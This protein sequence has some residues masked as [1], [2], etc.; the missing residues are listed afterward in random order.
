MS[1]RSFFAFAT[2]AFFSAIAIGLPAAAAETKRDIQTIKDADFFGFD[3]RTEQNVSLD[4]CK[5]SCIGDKSCKAFTYNPKVKWCFLKSDF[6]TMNAFP[7][8]VAGKIVETAAQKEPDIGAAPR[9]TFLSND[10]IQ[11]AHDY[12]DNLA[13]ADG[14]QG[15]G[16][17][18]LTANARLDMTENNLTDALIAFHGALSI[19]PDDA[20]LWLETARAAIS[21]GSTESSVTGQAVVDALNGYELTRTKA[22]RAEALAVLA[23]ALERNANYRPALGAYK[24][25]LALIASDEVQTAYLQ[26]KS[27]QGFR[28]TEHT[29]DADSV[30]PRACA[31]FSEALVKTTDYTPFVT[32]NGAA[33]KAVETKDKQICVEGLTHGETYKITFRPGLPSSVDESLDAPVSIDVYIKD[34]SQIVRFTG[35]SFVL[36]STA[37]RGIPIVSVNLAS[38]NLKLYRIG[39]R[40]IAPLLTNSQFLSQL[41]GYSAQNI[42][43][44]SGE[45]VW[46]GSID[47]ANE[48]NKDIVTSFPVDE[49]LPERKPGIYVL[50]A[51]APNAPAQEWDSQATQWFLVSDIGIT[52]YAGT[53]GLNVFARSLASAKPIAGVEL[54]LLAKNNEVLGTATTDE[55]GRATFTAGL[56]RGTAALTPAVIAA[57]NGTSDYVFLDMTRAG[58]D[59]SDRGV[60]GRVAPGA[61]DVLTFTERGIYR[62][63]ET[64]HTQALARDTDGNAIENLPLTF[65]FSRPDGVEDRRIVSQ[66]SNLGGYSVDFATQANAM[67]GTWTMNIYTDP[68]GSAI[69]SKS[70]LIDDFVPDR[71]DME[72]KTE[73]K[74]IGPD[75]P[76]NIT[77]SGKYLYGAPAAGLTLEGDVVVKPTRENEAY[78]GFLFGLA[79]EEASED[80]R[81][82]I[83]DLPELDENGE[84]STDLTVV[85][86][87]ATTQLLNATV[88]IRMQEA[89]GR[90]IERSLVIPVKSERASVGI[91]PEFSGDLPEN[92]IANFT[93]IGVDADGK[94]QEMKGLRWKFY[95]LNREY[96]WYREGTAWKYEP[97]YTAEQI[98]NGS[99]D[100]TM[101]GG[102]VS[103]PVTWGRYRLEVESPDA[104]GPTSS[105]EFDAGWFVTSTSTETPDGLEIALDKD[106]YKVGETAKLKVTSR[107]GGELMVTAGSE[108]LI[109]VQNAAI[110]ETGGEVDI[111]VTA[112]WGAGAYVTATL[113]RPGDAQDSHMPMRSIGIKW[114]KVDPE[115]R[116]LQVKLDTPEKMLPRGPLDI[117]LQVAGAGANE[118]A[119]VT[120]AAVDVGILNLTRYEPPNP[121]DWYFGQRQLGLEIRDLYGRLIDGSLG[122]TGKLRTG[123]DGG[124]VALQ[125]SPPT[126]KLVAFFSGPVKLDA[127]GK[128]HISFDIPQF[129][130]TA[131]VMAVAWTKTGVGHGVKDVIIRDP[132][133]VTASLPK[134]LTPGD[135]ADLRLDIAN[136]DAPAGDYKLQLTG[137][138][139]IG[140]EQASAAQTIRLEAGAKSE[141]TLSLVGKQ[142]GAGSVS[143]NLSDASGLSLDQ[144]IDVPV[145]PASLPI[146]QRR[147]LALKP[148]AKL[149]VDK[150][151]LAD[152]VLPG[153]SIS[154]NVTRSAAF[155]IP[156]LLMTLDRY[157]FGCAEQ[158][159][160]RALPLLYLAEV[161]KQAGIENDDDVRSRVQDAIYRVLSYQASAG[162]FGLWGPD[163]GDVWLD[164]YVTD[165]LTRAR[166]M[167][168]DVPEKAFVQALENLQNT[169]SYTTDIKGQGDQIAY[170]VYVLARNKKAAISDLRYYAD[171][172]IND[173]PTPL[174]KAH[175]AAALALYGDAQRSKNI[176][177][178][179]LQMSQQSMVSRVNLSRTDYGTILR[180]GAAILALAAESRPVPPVVPDLAKAVAK[181]WG[182]SKYKSTQEE[183]WMLLAARA[184]QGGDD[185][186]KVDVNGA[187]HTGAYMARMTGDALADHPLTLTNQTND[188]V[189]AVVT[190]VAAP[191]VP[192]PAGGDGFLIERSYYTL[193]GEQANV[194]EA[195]QNERYVVVIHVRE[196][197]DW[198]SRIVIT[199]LL[200]AGFEIDNPNLV[201]SAQMTN[202]DWIGEISAA[203]TEFRYDRFVAAFNRAAGDNREF[204]VAYVVRAVTPGTYDHPAAS[205]EDMYRPELSARTATGKMEVVAAQ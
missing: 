151:L 95:S 14:Q 155:D 40:A 166:E 110:G 122:A 171:T 196:T 179:A 174:A 25:S 90:A 91:K 205:V 60:T 43:D 185:S 159:T 112:D 68:K 175:I 140:I 141:L 96:Q 188:T 111:P 55:N 126:Q 77:I 142:P 202:F 53:D 52:T 79:D 87:P 92:S 157:P 204:N 149:T 61:I 4:Q 11:Q 1:V 132:V 105:V 19:T 190:T 183:A 189:S 136:T 162:S 49:A 29:V 195:K 8:A 28:I 7:G 107:Y 9:L 16:I 27:T 56:I 172:M 73:A 17:D 168:Y 15:Q 81:L 21:F 88:Y 76:A 144:T 148:G 102:K 150:N 138:D 153:A 191:T 165:F 181:E 156:A 134:F 201:D 117:G 3:L 32:L 108:K 176:F 198:P 59:L 186:L 89:G 93:V 116:A 143:I 5:T 145:R 98:S 130:G 41:D 33:P 113:F 97:V 34:R 65:I 82:P 199:D 23:T 39:D 31:T 118:D 20:D 22:K 80:S 78:K 71:T 36:P 12:K 24:A 66:T 200:P 194:S 67:R 180:D 35:D 54:Q 128:A 94:K 124:A 187:A 100:A 48:L 69:A 30:T 197:N 62:A 158:T 160:S 133:V 164:S 18:S 115:Q 75:T 152:S 85:D 13:L 169:L 101:G 146:T 47:I 163:S 86:L 131:R 184:I 2:I 57:R 114:L 10:L 99:V 106:S 178:D 42:Q 121:E 193:D 127:E 173:F 154:V 6:K 63:G 83:D 84:A 170:A 129:N 45:L 161:A 70:F 123:G 147:V 64:V 139:A 177:V 26:L 167:K 119:Y 38:A 192:L 46:Q 137:N 58:F 50:T 51:T 203:H 120:V 104:D 72:I 103:V 135:K 182:R 74:E 125:A 109:A 44:Q 37:R